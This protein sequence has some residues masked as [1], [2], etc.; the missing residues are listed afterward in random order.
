MAKWKP[1][2]ITEKGL[3]LQAK[4][5]AGAALVFTKV[6]L[7]S[8]KP[9][10]LAKATALAS[11]KQEMTIASK[12]VKGNTCTIY[13]TST[14]KDV[15]V[16]YAASEL[17]LFAKDPQAG[18]ILFAVTTDDSPDIVPAGT[19]ATVITQRIGVAVS[20]SSSSNVSTV[21][22]TTGFITAADAR[23]ISKEEVSS[24][25]KDSNAHANGIAGNAASATKL[26]TARSITLG[27]DIRTIGRTFDG[28][29]D[30]DYSD[31]H[32][33]RADAADRADKATNDTNGNRIDTTYAIA[34][35]LL[36]E[37]HKNGVISN[38]LNVDITN[39]QGVANKTYIVTDTGTTIESPPDIAWGIREVC[40][41]NTNAVIVRITGIEKNGQTN[42]LWTNVYN[43]G[44][45][46]GWQKNAHMTDI[47]RNVSQLIN[48]LG[49]LRSTIN[50]KAVRYV[51][52]V[53][54]NNEGGWRL[55][56]DGWKEVWGTVMHPAD[57]VTHTITGAFPIPFNTKPVHISLSAS[58]HTTDAGNYPIAVSA[59][60]TNTM[61]VINTN[62]AFGPTTFYSAEGF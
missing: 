8:G 33:N 21:I 43:Y 54:G 41:V 31:I 10:N 39:P 40:F 38:A 30:I 2:V 23:N 52:D 26:Q 46:T 49:Y 50:G 4:V 62:S 57:G 22:E 20:I 15:T 19:S 58:V 9:A 29:Q 27:G 14:N 3:A 53:D 13:A 18:E 48:D 6:T 1:V 55:W 35:Y 37:A 42:C 7:G 17:G 34:G 56:S 28:T 24:H 12:Q 45:W 11:M 51:I 16:E 32:V 47:P 36:A 61:L 59:A 44:N 5:E 25:N 60:T